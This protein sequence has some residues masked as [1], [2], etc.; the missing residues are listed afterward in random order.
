MMIFVGFGWGLENWGTTKGEEGTSTS[1]ATEEPPGWATRA[2]SS[3]TRLSWWNRR[4]VGCSGGVCRLAQAE[5]N[6]SSA[7]WLGGDW[8]KGGGRF[9]LRDGDL[10]NGRGG[11]RR[12]EGGIEMNGQMGRWG[13]MHRWRGKGEPVPALLSSCTPSR[14]TPPQRQRLWCLGRGE[15]IPLLRHPIVPRP[16]LFAPSQKG[17]HEKSIPKIDQWQKG[18][19]YHLSLSSWH[20]STL[21]KSAGRAGRPSRV[22]SGCWVQ[23]RAANKQAAWHGWHPGIV[24]TSSPFSI[25]LPVSSSTISVCS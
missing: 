19:G 14:C 6:E 16:D 1:T 3:G 11:K 4:V 17:H 21:Q 23:Q 7:G 5:I 22:P 12:R 24:H 20:I 25:S 15:V 8:E 18:R 9:C 10:G 2:P 13:E